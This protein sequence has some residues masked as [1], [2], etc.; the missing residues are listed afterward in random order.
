MAAIKK[1]RTQLC[2]PYFT[3]IGV[4]A[5]IRLIQKIP[6]NTH[7]LNLNAAQINLY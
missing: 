6:E 1:A 5:L 3:W 2:D 7:L 4:G